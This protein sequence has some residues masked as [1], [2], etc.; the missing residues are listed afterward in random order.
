M[1]RRI[2]L[3]SWINDAF[4][5][6]LTVGL[7]GGLLGIVGTIIAA[8]ISK[9][10][11][12]AELSYKLEVQRA[13]PEVGEE[14][15]SHVSISYKGQ[16]VPALY[17]VSCT[18]ENTGNT[19]VKGQEIRIDLSPTPFILDKYLTSNPQPEWGIEAL[20]DT[21]NPARPGYRLGHLAPKRKVTFR[22]ICAASEEP[23]ATL[24]DFHPSEVVT[25]LP[26]AITA[27]ADSRSRSRIA[28]TLLLSLLIVPQAFQILGSTGN[29]ATNIVRLGLI[30]ALIP[31]TPSLIH[32]L[33][34]LLFRS[35]PRVELENGIIMY[36]GSIVGGINFDRKPNNQTTP[37]N[38]TTSE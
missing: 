8:K 18:I 36:N 38:F 33:V 2:R 6:Q 5:Q 31:F 9:G 26:R 14:L 37:E 34:N 19:L 11:P 12:K 16:P 4:W 27:Q 23:K 35:E 13:L 3:M 7:A 21:D 30:V 17:I 22:I 25:V 1:C 20:P 10:K 32:A 24:L 15:A 28:L 29:L